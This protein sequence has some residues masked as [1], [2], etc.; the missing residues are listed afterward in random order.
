VDIRVVQEVLGNAS[1]AFTQAA[2]Q[3]V[4]PVLHQAAVAAMDRLLEPA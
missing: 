4:R 1:P 3:H 2:Y